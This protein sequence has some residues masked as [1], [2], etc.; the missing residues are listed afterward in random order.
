MKI[1]R[2]IQ[3]IISAIIFLGG[4][5]LLIDHKDKAIGLC[6]IISGSLALIHYVNEA[7]LENINK[8]K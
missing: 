4:I 3:F 8:E 5:S 1:V 7:R 6:V 2:S